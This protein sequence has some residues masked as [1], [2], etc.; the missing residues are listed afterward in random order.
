MTM[1]DRIRHQI[2]VS[3]LSK[4]APGHAILDTQWLWRYV[5][6]YPWF[7]SRYPIRDILSR[8]VAIPYDRDYD[9]ILWTDIEAKFT[10]QEIEQID[11]DRLE[12]YIET[13]SERFYRE[14]SKIVDTD[15]FEWVFESWL[16]RDSMMLQRT[17]TTL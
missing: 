9:D 2:K 3:P 6:L 16:D 10:C 15:K 4:E 12:I 17:E 14:L 13:I 1:S 7:F 8:V 11:C 5:D